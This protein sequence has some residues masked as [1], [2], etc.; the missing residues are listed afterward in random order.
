ML[1]LWFV[2]M[3]HGD[4]GSEDEGHLPLFNTTKTAGAEGIE[5]RTLQP[6]QNI[7][8]R[9]HSHYREQ[10]SPPP[11]PQR[12]PPQPPPPPQ[13]HTHSLTATSKNAEM[14]KRGPDETERSSHQRPAL[15]SLEPIQWNKNYLL[16]L[17]ATT[18]PFTPP[19][20][21][22]STDLLSTL[23]ATLSTPAPPTLSGVAYYTT[24]LSTAPNSHQRH[25]LCSALVAQLLLSQTSHYA[26]TP[27]ALELRYKHAIA[28]W[29]PRGHV[30]TDLWHVAPRRRTKD[31][32][33]E[34]AMAIS[35][36]QECLREGE[37]VWTGWLVSVRA[38][39]GVVIMAT[40]ERE[41][42]VELR[43]GEV[44]RRGDRVTKRGGIRLEVAMECRM[45]DPEQRVLFAG[46]L[47]GVVKDVERSMRGRWAVGSWDREEEDEEEE[48]E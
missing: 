7:Y 15:P 34:A 6:T 44:L 19:I 25:Q 29:S 26:A 45:G 14:Q 20:L 47:A 48:E 38:A 4:S 31:Y 30:G 2:G 32:A 24:A 10:H 18:V 8:S 41:L 3:E 11:P 12:P 27:P 37:R 5:L 1:W 23:T 16:A 33:E 22:L 17:G 36:A 43:D 39:W 9:N 28:R 46:M 21:P 42:L 13:P 35:I 40:V